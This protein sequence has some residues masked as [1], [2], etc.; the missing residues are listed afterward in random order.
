MSYEEIARYLFLGLVSVL[1]FLLINLSKA[2]LT[3]LIAW[4][5][6]FLEEFKQL[7]VQMQEMNNKLATLLNEQGGQKKSIETHDN[8]IKNLF[9]RVND[10]EKDKAVRDAVGAEIGH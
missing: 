7:R 9:E 8:Q 4:F 1:V 5:K 6:S 10:L 3:G 2:G